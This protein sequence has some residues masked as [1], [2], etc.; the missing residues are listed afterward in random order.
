MRK[1]IVLSALVVAVVSLAA[2]VGAADKKMATAKPVTVEG[3]LIDTKCYSMNPANK[4]N[5]HETPS[6]KV[7][8]CAAACAK[9]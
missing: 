3:T 8:A 6:G 7:E 1:W 5:D 4:G 9:M 2:V